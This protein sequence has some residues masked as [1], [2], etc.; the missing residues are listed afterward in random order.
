M[1]SIP[2]ITR[3]AYSGVYSLIYTANAGEGLPRHEHSFSHTTVCIQG[4][5]I[6]RKEGKE[7]EMTPE[8]APLLLTANEWHEIEALAPNTIFMNQSAINTEV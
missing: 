6:V 3:Y 2:P 5:T 1:I 7:L 8:D 4:K